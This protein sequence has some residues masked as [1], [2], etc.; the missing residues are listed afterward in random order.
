MSTAEIVESESLGEKKADALIDTNL[1]GN[2]IIGDVVD[3]KSKVDDN[4]DDNDGDAEEDLPGQSQD[5]AG[6]NKKKNK[7]KEKKRLAAL[8][9]NEAK[10]SSAAVDEAKGKEEKHQDNEEGNRLRQS[11]PFAGVVTQQ[12]RMRIYKK[13]AES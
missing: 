1:G 12:E 7:Q 5:T 8:A 4:E 13:Y 6:G 2:V 10:L 11:D 9:E 3:I